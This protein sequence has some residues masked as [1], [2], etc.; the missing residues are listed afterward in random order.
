MAVVPHTVDIVVQQMAKS[1]KF[2]RALG[3]EIPEKE[4]NASQ[5]NYQGEGWT[6]G[7]VTEELVRAQNT[8]WVDPKGQRVTLAFRCD[9]PEEVDRVY[10]AMVKSGYRGVRE[11]WDAFWG[12]RY[13]C[14]EDPD[15]NR[16]DLFAPLE[17]VP[18]EEA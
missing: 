15:R 9:R 10:E 6:L 1:L 5:V 14:V 17:G 4:D 12:Q 3:L 7:W 2:Y 16:V 18:H 11:P 8:G 13:A